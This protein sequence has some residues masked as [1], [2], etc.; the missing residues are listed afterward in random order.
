MVHASG[1]KTVHFRHYSYW[2]YGRLIANHMLE[3]EP[4]GQSDSVITES[5]QNGLDLTKFMSSIS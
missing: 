2:Y 4:I 1:A 3:V 5:C